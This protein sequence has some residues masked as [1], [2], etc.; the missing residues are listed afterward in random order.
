MPPNKSTSPNAKK[1]SIVFGLSPYPTAAQ[2]READRLWREYQRTG[3]EKHRIAYEK[4]VTAI[5]AGLPSVTAEDRI[6]KLAWTEVE[7]LMKDGI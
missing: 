1:R 2:L 5:L 7:Q 4:H 6:K 3:K